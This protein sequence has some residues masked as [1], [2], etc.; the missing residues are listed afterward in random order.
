MA[1]ADNFHSQ[2]VGWSKIILPICG[3]GLLSTLFLFASSDGAPTEI[4][5]AEIQTL[6]R[7]QR[8][9]APQFSGVTDDGSIIAIGA[10]SAQ[11]DPSKPETL[12]VT[13][14]SLSAD[15][16]DGSKIKIAASE[17]EIDG[18]AKIA[19]LRG[20]ARLETSNGYT[21]E[22]NG[23]VADLETGVITSDGALEVR[24]PFGAITAGRVTFQTGKDTTGQ[25]IIFTNGV[26]LVYT[27]SNADA[28]ETSE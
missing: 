17:G 5:F 8:I 18:L 10:V 13:E 14:L 21:M 22:T 6:A 2:L 7:E 27:P 23:L 26:K 16:P 11:P 1:S 20:L 4:P 28:K 12:S 24:A 3:I 15:A 25:Q 19:R 9:N